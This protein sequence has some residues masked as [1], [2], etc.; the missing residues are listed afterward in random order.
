MRKIKALI[1]YN[2]LNLHRIFIIIIMM[3]LFLFGIQQQLWASRISGAFHLNLITFLKTS[4]LPINL[5]YIPILIINEIISSSDQEI[6]HVLNISKKE[7]FLGKFFTSAVINLAIIIVNVLILVGVAIIAKAPLKYSLYLISMFLLNIFTGLFCC[8]AIGLLIGETM[9]KFRYRILSYVLIILF[10]LGTNNFF[11]EPNI[12]T[13]IM[14]FDPLSSTFELF[15]LD[16]LTLYH[17]ML[18]N[19]IGLLA[20]YLIYN[21]KDLQFLKF[22]NKI[23]LC[24]LIVA[25]FSCLFVGSKYNPDR[26]FILK[27]NINE[28]YEKESNLSEGFTIES[29]NMKLKLKD[30]I[31]NDCNMDII[32]NNKNLNKLNLSL[33]HSLKVSSINVN[34]KEVEF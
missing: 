6:F 34:E 2:F 21:I 7:R 22:R 16:K 28:N 32:I 23:I 14:K 27:D 12:L 3:I 31:F 24:F 29:Y 26:Y 9:S 10:F 20:M 33:Y 4:W 19:L 5:I 18:W 1:R 11:K 15:S 17:F 25:I 30:R 13:P 8:S